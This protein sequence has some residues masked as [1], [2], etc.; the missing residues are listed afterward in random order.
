MNK[1]HAVFVSQ[2]WVGGGVDRETHLR[3]SEDLDRDGSNEIIVKGCYKNLFGIHIVEQT[4]DEHP[5][6]DDDNDLTIY[7]WRLVSG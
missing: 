5:D 3:I 2:V 7:Y 4:Q 6:F 1:Q